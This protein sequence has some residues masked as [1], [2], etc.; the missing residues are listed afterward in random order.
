MTN[1][2]EIARDSI[3]CRRTDKGLRVRYTSYLRQESYPPGREY[4]WEKESEWKLTQL[5]CPSCGTQGKIFAFE[6]EWDN[7]GEQHLCL[8]CGF[9]FIHPVDAGQQHHSM[10]EI[11][12]KAMIEAL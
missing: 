4:C 8:G 10:P 12:I 11:V 3:E 2:E 7:P 5:F 9:G 1:Q 6:D